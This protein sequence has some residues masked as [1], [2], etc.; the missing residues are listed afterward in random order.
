LH[1]PVEDLAD[2]PGLA[3]VVPECELVEV[4][5]QMLDS[6]VKTPDSACAREPGAV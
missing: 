6:F 5:L 4:V 1:E 3:A 2:V